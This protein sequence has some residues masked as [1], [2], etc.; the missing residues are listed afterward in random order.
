MALGGASGAAGG[1]ADP[2][3]PR[4]QSATLEARRRRAFSPVHVAA[5]LAQVA[6]LTGQAGA[7]HASVQAAHDALAQQL[8]QRLWLPP[9]LGQGW[10]AAHAQTL[11]TLAGLQAR[12]VLLASADAGFAALLLDDGLPAICPAPVVADLPVG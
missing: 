5:R 6:A 9:L 11:A 4:L 10:L 1:A 3:L 12:L 8:A 2:G 7:A